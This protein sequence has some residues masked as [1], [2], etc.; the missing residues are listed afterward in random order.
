MQK[1]TLVMLFAITLMVCLNRS[2]A[3]AQSDDVP[4]FELGGHTTVIDLRA[5]GEVEAGGP[6][7]RFTYNFTRH[8]ALDTEVNVL[9]KQVTAGGRK[10][11]GQ[12]GIK[13]G[14]R[15]EKV[16][17]FAKIRPGFMRFESDPFGGFE[18]SFDPFTRRQRSVIEPTLDVGGVVEIYPSKNTIVRFDAGDTIIR[19]GQRTRAS[20]LIGAPEITVGGFTSHNFQAGVG[21]ALRF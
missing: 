11:Q 15:K 12:F 10:I 14:A 21:F 5:L 20:S 18:L 17:V 9:T 1:K 13:A 4:K 3:R 8:I 6:G 7:A 19:F 16:G 2:A